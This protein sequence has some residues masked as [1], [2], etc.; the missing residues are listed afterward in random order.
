M[1]FPSAARLYWE[2]DG[3]YD[4]D[5][6]HPSILAQLEAIPVA[7]A[8]PQLQY[9][10]IWFIKSRKM[11]GREPPVVELTT[12]AEVGFADAMQRGAKVDIVFSQSPCPVASVR[13]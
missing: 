4:E 2:I 5:L 9:V 3:D 1:S 7:V 13:R 6:D 10:Q 12:A 11:A 8:F